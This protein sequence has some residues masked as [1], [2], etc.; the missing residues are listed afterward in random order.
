M[1]NLNWPEG[2]THKDQSWCGLYYKF[3]FEKNTAA[4]W[5]GAKWC[6]SG[7]ASSYQDG[8]MDNM[9]SRPPKPWS[10]P[11]D[12]LPPVGTVCE[13]HNPRLGWVRCEIVAHKNMD[14]GGKPHAIAWIDGNNLDQSQGN[15]FQPIKT[16]DQIAAE[17]R[18]TAIRELMDI[19]GVDCRVTAARLV[20]AGFKREVA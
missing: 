14:C 5:D 8:S 6:K 15:R 16:P 7:S 3:D 20:D 17:K 11:E 18:E 13:I 2:S 9:V 10:G 1:S 19:A 4:Y 12:G